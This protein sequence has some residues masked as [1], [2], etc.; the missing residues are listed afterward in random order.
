MVINTRHVGTNYK[1][2]EP[3]EEKNI[4][5]F[6]FKSEFIHCAFDTALWDWYFL[7]EI[8]TSRSNLTMHFVQKLAI[9]MDKFFM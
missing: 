1:V 8:I 6:A 5:S 7:G 2:T 9:T 4:C 3:L